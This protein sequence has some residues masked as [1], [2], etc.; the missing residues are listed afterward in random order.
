MRF[1]SVLGC[2]S[3]HTHTSSVS[4]MLLH[5]STC[6]CHQDEDP[7]STIHAP[8][9]SVCLWRLGQYHTVHPA[10]PMLLLPRFTHLTKVPT[11]RAS[12]NATPPKSLMIYI[13]ISVGV[14]WFAHSFGR[15]V[16]HPCIHL[17]LDQQLHLAASADAIAHA[18]IIL[19]RVISVFRQPHLVFSTI[20]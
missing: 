8:N 6:C 5:C 20:P 17:Q 2:N 12:A 11:L 1:C 4:P 15:T 9:C 16:Y 10:S 18:L 14:T 13:K 19:Q 7:R 3:T